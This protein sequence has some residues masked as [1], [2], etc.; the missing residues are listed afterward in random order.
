MYKY[1]TKKNM[2]LLF[3]VV[4][5]FTDAVDLTQC[6]LSSLVAAGGGVVKYY[7]DNC[8]ELPPCTGE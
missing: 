4:K 6:Y 8:L 5:M 7:Y 3:S 1:L 2:S